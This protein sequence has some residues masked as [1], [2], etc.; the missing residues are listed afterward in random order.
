M[1]DRGRI[2][3]LAELL[4]ERNVIDARIATVIGRPALPGHIGE[5]IAAEIFGLSLNESASAA[6][7]DG[8]FT[9]GP[10][11]GKSVNVKLYGKNQGVLDLPAAGAQVA[12]YTLVLVGPRS[13]AGSSKG[14]TNPV[15][16]SG[17]YLFRN[18]ELLANLG[19]K[20]VKIGI[21][22]SVARGLWDAAEIYPRSAATQ[23]VLDQGQREL[24]GLFAPVPQSP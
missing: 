18:D 3:Q 10:L 17:V 7:S 6:A 13:A 22:T 15:V 21:A 14:T 8:T 12:D 16:V 5:F 1:P 23:L 4:H 2:E 24:L 19:T 11:A 20:G 9:G